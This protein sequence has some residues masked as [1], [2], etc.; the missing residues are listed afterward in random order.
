M[1]DGMNNAWGFEMGYGW[2]ISL[3]LLV[4]IIGLIAESGRRRKN[5]REQKYNSPQDILKTRYAKG[6]ISKDEFDEKRRHIS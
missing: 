4:F 6:E 1:M 5:A 3:I 2:V